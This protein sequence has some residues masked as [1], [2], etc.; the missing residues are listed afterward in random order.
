MLIGHTCDKCKQKLRDNAIDEEGAPR[1]VVRMSVLPTDDDDDDAEYD[2]FYAELCADCF[3]SI[4]RFV[5]P[6]KVVRRR[7]K[8]AMLRRLR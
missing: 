4:K 7:R 3:S 8:R 2:S 6:R 1:F 5:D